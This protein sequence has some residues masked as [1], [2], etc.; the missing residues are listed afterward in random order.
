ML[1]AKVIFNYDSDKLHSVYFQFQSGNKKVRHEILSQISRAS[2]SSSDVFLKVTGDAPPIRT[3]D[4]RNLS[5][6]Q[7]ARKGTDRYVTQFSRTSGVIMP[8]YVELKPV[9]RQMLRAHSFY[10]LPHHNQRIAHAYKV[11][12]QYDGKH[13]R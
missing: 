9:N 1:R 12:N 2:K 7:N 4:A 5:L 8:A 11:G 10:E 13:T 6:S 3:P